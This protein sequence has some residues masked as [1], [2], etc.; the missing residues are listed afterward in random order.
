MVSLTNKS[1][2]DRH[3]ERRYERK[4][5]RERE[6]ERVSEVRER[7]RESELNLFMQ[8]CIKQICRRMNYLV[9]SASERKLQFLDARSNGPLK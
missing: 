3:K 8:T 1:E 2:R 9:W 6:R 7:E 5:L 4:T